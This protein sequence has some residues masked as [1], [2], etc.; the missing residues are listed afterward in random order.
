MDKNKF[1]E[2]YQPPKQLPKLYEQY[3]VIVI[4]GEPEGIAAAVSAARNGATTLLVEQRDGLGGLLTYGML[5][6]LDIA[7]GPDGKSV[8][9]GIFEEWHKLVGKEGAFD[10]ELAKAAF[11]KLVKDEPNITLALRTRTAEAMLS[12]DG[13]M[14][15]GVDIRNEQGQF[16]IRGK[17]F[18]DAT[19]DADFAAMAGV[20]FFVGG[21]DINLKD[22]FMSVTPIIHLTGVD[23]DKVKKAGDDQ[24]F[25]GAEVTSMTAWGFSKHGYEPKQENIRLRGLNIARVP[26]DDEDH[27]YINALLIFGVDGLDPQSKAAALAAGNREIDSIVAYLKEHFPAF[28]N[29]KIASYP[30]ELYVRETR[31]IRAEYELPMADLW[32][33]K[34]HW[35]SIGYGGYPVDVQATSVNDNGYVI[36]APRQYAIPFRSL[37][38]LEKEN[39]VVVGR[40]A[41]YTSIAAGSARIV[42]TG[43]ST[44]EAAGA[45]A[46]LCIKE[47]VNVTF[48]ELSEDRKLIDELRAVL[49][50]QG[51]IVEHFE[52]DYPYQGEYYDDSIAFLMNYGLLVADYDNDLHVETDLMTLH[53]SNLI[54][55]GLKRMN[56]EQYKLKE[57]LLKSVYAIP[58]V[59]EALLS[60][61]DAVKYLITVFGEVEP[62]NQPWKHALELNLIDQAQYDRIG[63]NRILTRAEGYYMAAF[64]LQKYA[65]Q[66]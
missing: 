44:G 55:N 48:R 42:P 3:D 43:M 56:E 64:A 12:E 21:E 32:Q 28:E 40:A 1:I 22:R 62:S 27:Y 33:R 10:I 53:F 17:R 41:G 26:K 50:K 13:S 58:N 30:T 8:N 31:H 19:Q 52:L 29:A 46:A 2:T 61:D 9:K 54:L 65:A 6:F 49:D 25:G 35:D 66:P 45:A 4:G 57:K 7:Q 39:I 16:T 63:E 47:N 14:V 20:P 37:V 51:A 24:L 34:D 15:V 60:R 38:P 18:I 59:D 23:W 36:A 5:N 11:Y